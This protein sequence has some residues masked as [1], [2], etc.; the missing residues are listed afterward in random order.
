[1]RRKLAPPRTVV[2]NVREYERILLGRPSVMRCACSR[3]RSSVA[4][5]RTC[6]HTRCNV[7]FFLLY[8]QEKQKWWYRQVTS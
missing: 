2:S 7:F 3:D 6:S 5:I 4:H 1:M 8:K